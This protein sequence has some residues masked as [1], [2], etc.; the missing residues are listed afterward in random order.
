MCFVCGES[1]ASAAF[2]LSLRARASTD[3]PGAGSSVDLEGSSL[4]SMSL[5]LT[6]L[7]VAFGVFPAAGAFFGFPAAADCALVCSFKFC[8]RSSRIL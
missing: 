4:D 8:S 2:A 3:L 7:A 6:A 1:A 5:S